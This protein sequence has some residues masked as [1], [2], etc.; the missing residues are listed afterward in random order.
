V[1]VLAAG[2][3]YVVNMHKEEGAAMAASKEEMERYRAAVLD[4]TD[5]AL[6]LKNARIDT[7]GV[8][9]VILA[10]N[11]ADL[12]SLIDLTEGRLSVVKGSLE[13]AERYRDQV[14]RLLGQGDDRVSQPMMKAAEREIV[15]MK[16]AAADLI[17]TLDSAISKRDKLTG[18]RTYG[19][20]EESQTAINT[21]NAE[22]GWERNRIA[23]SAPGAAP[24]LGLTAFNGHVPGSTA[25]LGGTS[26]GDLLGT[27]DPF[28][29]HTQR[30]LDNSEAYRKWS[31]SSGFAID[32]V[33][34]KHKVMAA[35]ITSLQTTTS[36][37][38]ETSLMRENWSRLKGV[39]V[40]KYAA[41]MTAAALIGGIRDYA[42]AKAG[43][44][45]AQG[46]EWLANPLTAAL[47][48]GA[49]VA[50]AKWSLAAGVAGGV[51]AALS[52]GAQ[53]SFD[54]SKIGRASC[55]ERVSVPV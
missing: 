23:A 34:N 32:K 2:I 44:N 5:A 42:A 46:F 24:S 55:R 53:K 18:G 27:P 16:K 11:A 19:P 29:Q 20:A 6:R 12:T 28:M 3:A 40:A 30:V 4:A 37:I 39:E 33:L 43:T 45:I 17:T 21:R 47:A 26:V 10:S 36:K 49:F 41:G 8:A 38:I 35:G 13:V 7:S 14:E 52:A 25:K 15:D 31:D 1:G 51:S 22:A 50:A 54:R 48:P 9:D